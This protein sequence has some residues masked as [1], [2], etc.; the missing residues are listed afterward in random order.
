MTKLYEEPLVSRIGFGAMGFSQSYGTANRAESLSVLQHL[1]DSK[2]AFV[3]TADIYGNGHNEELIGEW[4]AQDKENR[5]KV[6]L[7]TKFGFKAMIPIII[8][9]KPDYVKQ[10]CNASLERLGVK[11]IDLYYQ[12]RVDPETPIEETVTAMAE[13]VKEGKVKYI[14]LSEASAETIRRAHKVHPIAA[15]QVEYSPW[16]TDIENNGV[17]DTCNELGIVVVAFSPIGRG[18]LTGQY[19][20]IEDFE[21]ND[22]RRSLPRFQ[23]TAFADNLK[24]VDELKKIA[25]EKG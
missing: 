20:S 21:P 23:G 5:N 19:K 4:L 6:F 10:A 7:C 1:A 15:V 25:I 18:F 16:S 13:L 2:A 24:L 3:D 8:S 22:A 14:G 12:H 17:L 11:Y 9:G